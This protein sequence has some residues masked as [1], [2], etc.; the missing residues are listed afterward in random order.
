M[1]TVIKFLQMYVEGTHVRQDA[2]NHSLGM[3]KPR[4]KL[5]LL[6]YTFWKRI[7]PGNSFTL[8]L[9]VTSG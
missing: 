6:T 9:T 8:D 5:S 3:F 4:Q 7:A 2:Q 1:L